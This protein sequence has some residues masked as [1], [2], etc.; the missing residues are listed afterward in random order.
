MKRIGNKRTDPIQNM[1]KNHNLV[2]SISDVAWGMQVQATESKAEYAGSKVL[3]VD[4]KYLSQMCSK[5][6]MMVKKDLSE[7]I[8]SRSECGLPTDRDLNAA[9]SILRLGMQSVR[10]SDRCPVLW[11]GKNPSPRNSF[12]VNNQ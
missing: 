12:S 5:C 2:K 4:S 1:L 8:H 9:I 11:G 10:K 3:L 7:R 6:S